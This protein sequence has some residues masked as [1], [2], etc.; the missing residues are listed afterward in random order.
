[1]ASRAPHPVSGNDA[2]QERGHCPGGLLLTSELHEREQLVPHRTPS[3][4]TGLATS[5]M[6]IAGYLAIGIVAFW[7]TIPNIST[8]LFGVDTDYAQSVWFLAWV[9]HALGSGLNPFFSQAIFAPTGVNLV[10]N[11]SSPLLGLIA[12][13]IA[14]LVSPIVRANALMLLAMPLSATAGFIVLAKWKVWSPAAAIGGLMYG[15][16]PY[17]VGQAL[18]HVELLFLP[19]PPLIAL[20]VSRILQGRG[21][22]RRMGIALGL[23][24]TGQFLISPEVFATVCVFVAVAIICIATRQWPT[25]LES[26][27]RVL[28]PAGIALVTMVALLAYPTWMLLAGPQHFTGSPWNPV[29]PF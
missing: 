20:A 15:F 23:L 3:P 25:F 4:G 26:T 13:P 2:D 16:S 9:P 18:G 7:P 21:S 12:A 14:D 17:M 6:V 22:P 29:N 11:T 1:M 24:L 8:H 27:R 19:L 10:E 28:E 5:A